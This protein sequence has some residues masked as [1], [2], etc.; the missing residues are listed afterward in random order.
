[1]E[2]YIL[3]NLTYLKS[4][5]G[6]PVRLAIDVIGNAAVHVGGR[7][8]PG[9]FAATG[10]TPLVALGAN[11]HKMHSLM[12]QL[13]LDGPVFDALQLG[14]HIDDI[15]ALA[16]ARVE[17]SA[18]L[19]SRIRVRSRELA[20]QVERN[21]DFIRGMSRERQAGGKSIAY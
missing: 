8:Q 19:R 15:V 13:R 17:A 1:M 2:F 9:I 12:D 5:T 21:M 18:A 3:Q 7:W 4:G 11:T 10:G 14:R 20:A 16:R 6:S